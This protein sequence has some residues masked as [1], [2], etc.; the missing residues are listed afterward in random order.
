MIAVAFDIGGTFTDFVLHDAATGDTHTLKVP[1]TPADPSIAVLEGLDVILAKAARPA[2]AVETLLHATTVATNAILERKGAP[3]GLITTAGFRDVLIIGRQKR[4]ETYD[5]YISKPQPLVQRRHIT[6][7]GE[8]VDADGQVIAA[9]DMASVDAAIDAMRAAGRETVAVALL[10][11][12]ANADHERAIAARIAARAPDMLVS[13]SSDVSPKF[14]EYERTNTTVAN[15]YVR[16]V[17]AHYLGQL[18]TAFR[19]QG[20]LNDF[21]IM[22]SNGGLVSPTIAR[23]FPVRII[24]S[25]P[26]AG[27]LMC[28][29]I[30]RAEGHDEIVTFDM[31]GTTAKL[32]AIDNGTPAIMP[33]LEVDLVRHKRGS[34]LPINVPAI[35]ML[36]I[37]AGGGSIARVDRGM[38]AVG[39]DSAGADPGPVCYGRGG[40][41]PTITDANVVLGYISPET[42]NAG[43]M[44]LDAEAARQAIARDIAEPLGLSAIDAAWGVYVIAT[45]NMENALRLVSIERGRDPRRYAMVAFGGAGPVHAAR[46]AR[47]LGIPTVIVPQG[48]GVGSAIGLLQAEPRLD[49]STTGLLR[50]DD[51]HAE[52]KITQIYA[53]LKDRALR[54]IEQ[55]AT[56]AEATWTRFAQMRY[57]GQ[58]FEIRVELPATDIG[59]D[60]AQKAI[61]AFNAAYMQR[62]KFLDDEG[63]IEAVDWSLVATL[64][65]TSPDDIGTG[66]L[67]TAA[68][69]AQGTRQ[70]WFP[71]AG[72]AIETPVLTRADLAGGQALTGPAIIEDADCTIVV[73]PGDR[74]RISTNGHLVIE[75]AKD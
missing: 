43:A 51:K 54:E 35:E 73:P 47:S 40:T 55:V 50:L 27:I 66:T 20:L 13:I 52:A 69:T 10:H 62:N 30:G 36:E 39:P 48:A 11:A 31:G 7:V 74:A 65:R 6:E 63:V 17:V 21:L 61:A 37:G 4:Y 34:G 15:A 64:P 22:Q 29:E 75:I 16:P 1:T 23:D 12:Y 33:T 41:A 72:G 14:R 24:E 42:F 44:R 67:D 28:A 59:P 25:G 58:G 49:V 2:A 32:G 60:Y 26:A 19:E 3:T 8:R 71:D 45:S 68:T 46:L 70:C 56:G 18:E 57:A 5:L 38:I 53:N 9:L